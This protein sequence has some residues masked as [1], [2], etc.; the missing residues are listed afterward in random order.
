MKAPAF[1]WPHLSRGLCSVRAAPVL[2]VGK[3]VEISFSHPESTCSLHLAAWE[4][5]QGVIDI[6]GTSN[7]LLLLIHNDASNYGWPR[8][9]HSNICQSPKGFFV[10]F[11]Q[12]TR[13]RI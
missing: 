12:R 5:F 8:A 1:L 3:W 10:C 4:S 2:L 13:H 7:S 9:V 6:A 11:T